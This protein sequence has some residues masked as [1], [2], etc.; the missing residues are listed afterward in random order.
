MNNI[1]QL[2]LSKYNGSIRIYTEVNKKA[3]PEKLK[4]KWANLLCVNRI[5]NQNVT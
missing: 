4:N 5:R 1:Q 2:Q 3:P